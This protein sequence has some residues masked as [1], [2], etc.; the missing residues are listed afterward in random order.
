MHVELALV[1]RIVEQRFVEDVPYGGI[2][3]AQEIIL[4]CYQAYL[5]IR[6]APGDLRDVID[7]VWKPCFVLRISFDLLLE[8][9]PREAL[10]VVPKSSADKTCGTHLAFQFLE[11][12]ELMG[13]MAVPCGKRRNKRKVS[14]CRIT[15][16]MELLYAVS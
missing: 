10:G 15:G 9:D 5:Q 1:F 8:K 16:K 3:I 12:P 2:V 4:A 7:I 11:D 13:D 6:V 14:A